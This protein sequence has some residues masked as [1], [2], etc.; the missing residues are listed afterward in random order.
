MA[1][2][3]ET[4]RSLFVLITILLVAI[5]LFL[6]FIL[7]S[8][9]DELEFDFPS[10]LPA[11][12]IKLEEWPPQVQVINADFACLDSGSAVTQGG[13]TE[14][15]NIEGRNFCVT[16]ISEGAAG[17]IYTDYTY[18]FEN[19]DDTVTLTFTTR[20]P[21]CGNYPEPEMTECS[22]ER[23]A[24]SIDKFIADIVDDAL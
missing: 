16:E 3:Y 17:S 1:L 13:R 7:N 11:E 14:L 4:V 24:F 2:K 10:S 20:A 6:I 19:N 15:R 21:Q 23:A 8:G 9:D 5:A 18:A 12:Y 22:E